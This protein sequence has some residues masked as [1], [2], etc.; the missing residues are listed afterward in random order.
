MA[1]IHDCQ[2]FGGRAE[3][4]WCTAGFN[5]IA[6]TR[7]Q[8]IE[9]DERIERGDQLIVIRMELSGEL[10]QDALDFTLLLDLELAHAIAELHGGGRL[11]EDRGAGS[12]AIVHDPA[13]IAAR[14][15]AHGHD[16]PSVAH[17]NRQVAHLV[18]RF[19]LRHFTL[20]Q[21]H[22]LPF[23]LTQFT[24]NASQRRRRVVAHR[25]IVR[26]RTCDR[27]FEGAA[28]DQLV[29]VCL[30]VCDGDARTPRI[31][32]RIAHTS[33]GA[34]QG[35][36]LQVLERRPGQ[37]LDAKAAQ[38]LTELRNGLRWPRQLRRDQ[39]AHRTHPGVFGF[40]PLTIPPGHKRADG[41]R[42]GAGVRASRDVREHSRKF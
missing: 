12:R 40:D 31:A 30:Q 6:R 26:N 37:P 2:P 23:G 42:S 35:G 4:Q 16:P 18:M 11:H 13:H 20:E 38:C 17:R 41:G 29:E 34:D 10:A 3:R 5:G 8:G 27:L 19:E 33:R 9:R 39:C 22:E 25:A 21:A 1:A 24:A 14:F 28:I 7:V 36:T 32:K 15:A